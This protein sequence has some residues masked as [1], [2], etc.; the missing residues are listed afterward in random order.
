MWFLDFVFL[1]NCHT[2]GTWPHIC[3]GLNLFGY[4]GC[5]SFCDRTNLTLDCISRICR[6]FCPD[7]CWLCNRHRE[8]S[9]GRNN[10]PEVQEH[11][12]L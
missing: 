12:V 10:I 1:L 3:S 9:S 8:K 11:R 5:W 6:H 7:S 4:P 2:T